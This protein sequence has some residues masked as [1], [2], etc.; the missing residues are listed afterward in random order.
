MLNAPVGING[1]LVDCLSRPIG[2]RNFP[3][4]VMNRALKSFIGKLP[5][6]T[7]VNH[8]RMGTTLLDVSG[9]NGGKNHI[10]SLL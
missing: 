10:C 9:Q 8:E 5:L 4:T 2:N 3:V 1:L 6:D 7:A